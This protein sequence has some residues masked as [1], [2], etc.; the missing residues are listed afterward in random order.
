MAVLLAITSQSG[1]VVL[2][3]EIENGFF[4]THLDVIWQAI[5]NYAIYDCQIFASTHS[6]ECL[7]AVAIS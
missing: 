2:V 4:H 1:G 6:A 7:R 3:D 5:F